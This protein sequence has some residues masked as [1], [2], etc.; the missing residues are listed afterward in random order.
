MKQ[1]LCLIIVLTTLS[2]LSF[3]EEPVARSAREFLA[4]YCLDCHSG[5]TPE[6]DINLDVKEIAWTSIIRQNGGPEFLML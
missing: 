5:D 4:T 6:A 2:R 1:L 3:A